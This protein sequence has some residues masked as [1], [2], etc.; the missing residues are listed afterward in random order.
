MVTMMMRTIAVSM[1]DIDAR[2]E[3]GEIDEAGWHA[4][5]ARPVKE[6]FAVLT[7]P[8]RNSVIG[9]ADTNG[10]DSEARYQAS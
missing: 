2:L 10:A 5:I 9:G 3:R 8:I 1:T 7:D 4:E 6:V